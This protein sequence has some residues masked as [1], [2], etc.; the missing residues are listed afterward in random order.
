MFG[1]SGVITGV[2]VAHD[3]ATVDE[4]ADAGAESQRAEVACLTAREE[5]QEAFAIQTC[6]RAEA[7]VVTADAAEGRAA[8][9]DFAPSVREEAVTRMD[10]EESLRHVMRV[11][12]G[13]ESLVLGEDH[14]LGQVREAYQDARGVGGIGPTLEEAITKAIH[15]G[16]RVRTETEI[17]EGIVSLGSAAAAF[18]AEE[19]D[20]D[21]AT[22]AVVGAGEMGT[23]T[24]KALANRGIDQLL[25]VN[26]TVPHAEHVAAAVD[27]DAS[28]HGLSA[29]PAVLE[30]ADVVVT[31]SASEE[32]LI[33][34]DDAD[35]ADETTFVDLAQPRDVDPAVAEREPA[36]VYDLDDLE[37]VTERTRRQRRAAAT[38]VE[39]IIDD[40]FAHLLERYKR[41]RADEVIAGMYEGAEAIKTAEV[42]R[43][44]EQAEADGELS[45]AQ[46]E[47]IESMADAL[48]NKLLA[49]PT[50]SLRDAAAKD[51]WTTIQTALQL[52]DPTVEG[53]PAIDENEAP[54][55]FVGDAT[56][57]S[58][59]TTG[60]DGD[61]ATAPVDDD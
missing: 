18:A 52:F 25:V 15:V 31:S 10:H 53:G 55:G 46:R 61:S 47:A 37:D 35:G 20:L 23:A 26:R 5:V 12:A 6:N 27:A 56:G 29:I 2:S 60:E 33:D 30:Q 42:Q 17:N 40:E 22:A 57:S 8:F 38:E 1:G 16:E 3:S 13:L 50:S 21:G 14:V 36:T 7:Y 48:V 4:I 43:A 39:A 24:A 44:I 19:V 58:G 51:D 34:A 11:A 54:P 49:A 9:D 45:A 28:A 32:P 59:N 41:K